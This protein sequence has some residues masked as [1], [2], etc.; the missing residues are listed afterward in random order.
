MARNAPQPK[1]SRVETPSSPASDFPEEVS[2]D[3]LREKKRAAE[4][5]AFINDGFS[6]AKSARTNKQT[7]WYENLSFIFGRQWIDVMKGNPQTAN[8]PFLRPQ[9]S[10]YYRKQRTINRI[11]SFQRTEHSKFLQAIPDITVVPS[12]AENDD[13]R[14]ALAGEQVWQSIS[15][16]Q[17]LRTEFSNAAWWMTGVGTGIIK[18]WWDKYR[19]DEVSGDQ[20]CVAYGSITPFHLYIPDLRERRIDDQP[21][22]IQA[23]VK[24][25]SWV[26]QQFGDRAIGI[27]ATTSSASA[28]I[29]ES[30]LDLSNSNS[31]KPDSVIVK[32]CW[33]KP[34]T[35]QLL[36]EGGVVV[37]VEDRVMMMTER[38]PYAH[39]NYPYTI[40][41]HID[42]STFY[43]ESPIRDIIPLQ[44]EYNEARTDI[45][46]AS[47]R[48]G[49]PQILAPKG[50]VVPSKIT[51]EPGLVIEY[52]PGGPAPQWA[53]PPPLPEYVVT[54][55]DRVLADIE[56]IGG[57]HEVTKGSAP[58]GVTAGTA[59]QYLGEQDSAY[60]TP[61]F[62]NIE[63]G[64]K[65]IAKQTLEL[66]VQYVDVPRAI[67]TVGRDQAYDMVQLA[68]ADIKHGTDVR[69]ERGSAQ[70]ESKAAQDARIMDMWSLGIIT[71]PNI[72]LRLLELGGSQRILDVMD[73]ARRK[74]M[75]ENS[76]M[77]ALTAQEVAQHAQMW[78][79]E[80]MMSAAPDP[81]AIDDPM[82]AIPAESP[83]PGVLNAS[84]LEGPPGIPP[85][86]PVVSVEDFDL[87]DIHIEE[88]NKFRMGQE[89]EMLPA[90]VKEEF[91]KH[92]AQHEQAMMQGQL[93]NFLQMIPEDGSGEN[94]DTNMD[95]PVAGMGG[96]QMA[97]NGQV[98]APPGPEMSGGGEPNG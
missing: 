38:F 15:D 39:G 92:V 35:T 62:M 20:G 68:G 47:R 49:R 90:E 73:V 59:L 82:Q 86:P 14:A 12:T 79:M 28:I 5:A 83:A 22:V 78:E 51:N 54:I 88:H 66:F 97:G 93:Q 34:G 1:P 50:S 29:D 48:S 63:T 46:E 32:E 24:P 94:P 64:Y 80:Q 67:K 36:P 8:T 98:P 70:G 31:D 87:H 21:F 13:L 52:L 42:T 71:D 27:D 45:S 58:T 40:F 55:P 89:Y 96:A 37:L 65:R 74:A 43:A 4:L 69:V 16:A 61:Q 81:M 25:L 57:Q 56:D 17:D 10:P 60:R 84:P 23:M 7:Q 33:I 44:K 75:R 41:S 26:R 76:K 95:V 30:Y 6:S 91:A 85:A 9:R 72:A 2:L 11:R 77:K 18:T 53:P 19:K 3:S